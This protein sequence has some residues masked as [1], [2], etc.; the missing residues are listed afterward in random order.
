VKGVNH[1]LLMRYYDGELDAAAARELERK[2][3]ADA[4]AAAV[5]A[6]LDQLGDVLR[7]LSD[8]RAANADDIADSVLAKIA[9]EESGGD[10]PPASGPRPTGRWSFPA[11]S[12]VLAVAAVAVLW[13]AQQ[14]APQPTAPVAV[15]PPTVAPRAEPT[16]S[17]MPPIEQVLPVEEEPVAAAIES[18][19][20]G[21]HNGAIFLVSAGAEATPVVW[22]T[23]DAGEGAGTTESL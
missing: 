20:F 6:G 1:E 14:R 15:T 7:T 18:V 16:V 2:L 22:L 3:D 5:V 11:V 10:A 21:T 23:D 12:A 13:V 4:E 9:A 17:V 19:D 8:R